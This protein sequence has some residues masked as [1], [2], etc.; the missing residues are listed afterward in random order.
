MGRSG[1][2]FMEKLYTSSVLVNVAQ[3]AAI[4][5]FVAILVQ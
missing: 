2:N 3:T 5:N 1:T 4:C